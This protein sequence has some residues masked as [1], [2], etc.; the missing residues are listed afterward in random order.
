MP[1][2]H[3]PRLLYLSTILCFFFACINS[4]YT[5]E[6]LLG[7]LYQSTWFPRRKSAST[8][9]GN[10]WTRHLP[11][12]KRQQKR[13]HLC[14]SSSINPTS[15]PLPGLQ[16]GTAV[17]PWHCNTAP[18]LVPHF[19]DPQPGD[20]RSRLEC[21]PCKSH[22]QFFFWP[23]PPHL[24]LT[25]LCRDTGEGWERSPGGAQPVCLHPRIHSA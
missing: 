18:E 9:S 5:P 19:L 21:P 4:L 22:Q 11:V 17:P 15:T 23:P 14:I 7:A 6:T 10:V 25:A 2:L 20:S 8:A 24:H 16:R 12:N 13:A 1:G 3:R